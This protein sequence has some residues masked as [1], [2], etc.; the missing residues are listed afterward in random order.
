MSDVT[1][2]EVSGGIDWLLV[3]A[4]GKEINGE[5]VPPL[6][7]LFDPRL[8]RVIDWLILAKRDGDDFDILTTAEL[9]PEKVG[10][11]GS[12]A[13]ASSGVLSRDDAAAAAAV[14]EAG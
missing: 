2:I 5:L 10:D 14:L 13:G 8:V 11:L 9:N 7:D 12:L 1:D 3:E 6:L 4:K